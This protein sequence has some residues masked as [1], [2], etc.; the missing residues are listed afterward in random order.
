MANHLEDQQEAVTPAVATEG[1]PTERPQDVN[2]DNQTQLSLNESSESSAA[3]ERGTEAAK[4]AEAGAAES[5][6]A[7]KPTEGKPERTIASRAR[8][9]GAN[10]KAAGDG[11]RRH[12]GESRH[13]GTPE[14]KPAETRTAADVV[15]PV[16]SRLAE[17]R[18]RAAEGRP[19]LGDGK[20][21]A[22]APGVTTAPTNGGAQTT[23]DKEHNERGGPLQ[24]VEWNAASSSSPWRILATPE[25]ETLFGVHHET[26]R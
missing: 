10:G 12:G 19:P 22:D 6:P 3:G 18:P 26:G 8:T 1:T 5:A 13:S 9:A 2:N 7:A 15:R 17:S 14:N 11:P 16:E 21:S 25:L 24:R 23:P 4:P 20:D